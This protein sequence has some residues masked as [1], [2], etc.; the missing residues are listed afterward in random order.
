MMPANIEEIL[1]YLAALRPLVKET[2][3]DS[4]IRAQFLKEM[5]NCCMESGGVFSE[6]ET[7]RKFAVKHLQI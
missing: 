6:K 2:I 3:H 5:A 7:K 1:D 4:K